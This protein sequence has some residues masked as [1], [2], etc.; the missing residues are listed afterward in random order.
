MSQALAQT[1]SLSREAIA[2][3]AEEVARQTRS[4]GRCY[5][6]VSKALQPLGVTLTGESAYQAKDLLMQDERFMPL[7][8]MHVDQLERGDIVV[9]QKSKGKPHGHISVYQG[10]Y[11][12]ASDHLSAVTHTQAYGGATV[13]RLRNEIVTADIP[14]PAPDRFTYQ[15]SPNRFGYQPSETSPAYKSEQ[16]QAPPAVKHSL[17]RRYSPYKQSIGRA[18]VRAGLRYLLRG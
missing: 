7:V 17:S 9:Y 8:I 2:Q 18:I 11:E 15:P 4:S 14:R 10:N 1:D 12:E 6:A 16:P 5:A 13:F 3:R